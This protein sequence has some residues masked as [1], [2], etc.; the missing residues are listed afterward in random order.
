MFLFTSVAHAHPAAAPHVHPSDPAALAIL[1][2]WL[3]AA[4]LLFAWNF[5]RGVDSGDLSHSPGEDDAAA[6]PGLAR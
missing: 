3:L 1:A 5:R 2:F 6:T 4:G